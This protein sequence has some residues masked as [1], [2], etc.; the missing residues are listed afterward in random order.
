MEINKSEAGKREYK[1]LNYVRFMSLPFYFNI[2]NKLSVPKQISI[3]SSCIEKM[4]EVFG[5]PNFRLRN[6]YLVSTWILNF[7][8]YEIAV[9]TANGRGTTFEIINEDSEN[10]RDIIESDV[11]E[12]L[13]YMLDNIQ[14]DKVKEYEQFEK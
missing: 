8:H 14:V 10:K 3:N 1:V 2:V 4:T 6:E 12:F 11:E 5:I 9:C 7:K 13:N